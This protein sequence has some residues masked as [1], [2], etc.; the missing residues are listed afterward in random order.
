MNL[1]YDI[2]GQQEVHCFI[3]VNQINSGF[4]P[5]MS[6]LCKIL[7]CFW[8]P[9]YIFRESLLY[10]YLYKYMSILITPLL[11]FLPK[12]QHTLYTVIT[13]P[14]KKKLNISPETFPH[15]CVEHAFILSYRLILFYLVSVPDFI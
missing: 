2:L 1:F 12:K 15:Q 6:G 5:P 4:V 3:S 7:L 8:R 14:K 11:T 9:L 10:S 13:I